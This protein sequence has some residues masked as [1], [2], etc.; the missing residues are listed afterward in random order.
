MQGAAGGRAAAPHAPGEGPCARFAQQLAANYDAS[1]AAGDLDPSEK[2]E[3]A[4]QELVN[5]YL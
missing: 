1:G 2:E 3:M 4:V 5:Q